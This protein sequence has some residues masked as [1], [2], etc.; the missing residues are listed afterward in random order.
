MD[1]IS[2]NRKMAMAAERSA[3][4][5]KKA[6]A[7][8]DQ[9]VVG[10]AISTANKALE[11]HGAVM[12]AY[13]KVMGATGALAE[14]AVVAVFSKLSFMQGLACLPASSQMD[15]VMGIDVH[16]VMIPPSPS[17]IP[18][19]HPYIAMVFNP[20]DFI[21]C[22]VMSAVAS[23]P[24]PPPDS[25]GKQLASTVGKMALGMVMAKLGLGASVKL[26]GFTPRTVTG[27]ANKVI[28]H[29]PMGASFAPL[30]ILKNSGHAQ[31][32][33]LFLLADG[34]PFTGMMHLNNDCWDIGI[35]QLMRKKA[36]AEPMHLFMPTGFVMAI[37]SH[38]VI[39]NPI[40]TPI[41]PIAALTKVFNFGLAKI[42]HKL[43]RKLPGG[44]VANALHKAVCHVTGHPV[45]I[46]SGMLFTDEEDFDLPGVIP[47][48]WER[49][50]YSDSIYKGPLG[51]GWYHNYDMGFSIDENN[52]GIFRM[53]DGRLIGFE[54]PQPGKFM[55]DRAE[56]YFLHRHA[57]EDYYYVEDKEG[58]LY[59]F[60]D[61]V[62]VNAINQTSEHLLQSV[63]NRNGYAIR[64]E[65][66]G[67]GHL[68]KMIDSAGRVL[69]V[70]NDALGRILSIHAP[71]PNE[72]GQTFP[73]ARYEY[74]E[75]G[76]M[77]R[78][79]DAL[80]QEMLYEYERTLLVKETWRNG[81]NWYFEYDG[82][83]PGAKCIHTW[84]DG[85]IY[86]HKLTYQ[87]GITL[88][89][90]SLGFFTTYYL[91]G[92]LISSKIDGNGAEWKYRYNKFNELEW[93]TDPLGNQQSY[94]HDEWGNIASM[95]DPGGG[96][97][98]TE[99]YNPK[100][101]F[102]PTEVL[103]AAG[104]K[105]KWYYDEYGNVVERIDPVNAKTKYIYSDG[106]LKSMVDANGIV[107]KLK[108]DQA[109]NLIEIETEEG[110]ITEYIYDL[111]G[112]CKT[113]IN[114]NGIKQKVLLDR[115]GRVE[116]IVDF[117]GNV[118][119]LTYD[120]MDNLV[121]YRDKLGHAECTYTGLWNLT[122]FSHPGGSVVFK[123]DTEEQ[124]KKIINEHGQSYTFEVDGEGNVVKEVNFNN[125]ERS[126]QYN[127]AGWLIKVLR[128]SD[129]F[130]KYT[131][132][133]CGR[134]TEVLYSDEKK[135]T[136]KYRPDGELMQA[137]NESA[138]VEF[139]RDLNGNINK[140]IVNGEWVASQ[141][142]ILGAL[143]KTESSLGANIFQKYN[144][145]G[146]ISQI[147]ANGWTATFD[148]DKLGLEIGR[149]LPGG[150]RNR[151]KRDGVGRPLIQ[152]VEHAVKETFQ[153]NR[154]RHYEW[155]VGNLI[156]VLKDERGTRSFKHDADINLQA[157]TRNGGELELRNPDSIGNI[158]KT[159][160]R[161][162]R[163][164]SK[165]GQLRKRDGWSYLYDAEGNLTQKMHQGGDV[166]NYAWNDAGMLIS[167][168]RPDKA[169]VTFEYDAFGRRISKRFKNTRTKFIWDANVP[170]H[171]WKEH[172]ETGEK[173][174]N[175]EVNS[176]G[177]IT[178]IFDN[179]S[180]APAA[181]IKGQERYSI[182]TDHL[183]TPSQIYTETGSLIW[184][185]E[186]D[187]Y[188]NLKMAI[189]DRGSCPFRFQGQYEDF[190]TGLYYNR[191]RYYAPDEGIYI[192]EDPIG[193]ES[194][195]LNFYRYVHDTANW[196]DVLGLKKTYSGNS[197]KSRKKN[198]VYKIFNK[199]TKEVFKFG[200]S[201]GKRTKKGDSVRA[202]SQ[203][204]KIAAQ[205]GIPVSDVGT[206]VVRSNIDRRSTALNIEQQK[207]N[208]H[209]TKH[210]QPPR[211]NK[212]PKPTN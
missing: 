52:T 92:G 11:V 166:W 55:Y 38:N 189:G 99:Y 84:G 181:K 109:Q 9:S 10:K 22:A 178:W 86:N 100:F 31:F 35:M 25:A 65:Y 70:K 164:Y 137:V 24:P 44:R 165:G 123:Y 172:A 54:L 50:W 40:P 180:S 47:F 82:K 129:K 149:K 58:L 53:N 91:K 112:N 185:G 88:V 198:H 177:V 133:P 48:S 2:E 3:A 127:D 68:V 163:A 20:K 34:E 186:L 169:L 94:T 60:T 49:T 80:D 78:H 104:G 141:Y 158:F 134:V 56:K 108:H 110:A 32:G 190:E 205:E 95:T 170:L 71:D 75:A 173:L 206:K 111:L 18:M 93:E 67:R 183:G 148:S 174:S 14:K 182:I 184:E 36:P 188:G 117:D 30:P 179:D 46:A 63:S 37:P 89:E 19:P 143:I 199:K 45:D 152:I 33:S 194:E 212:R 126:F 193:L 201:G 28:P 130:T 197:K 145:V 12:G 153:T 131:H 122:S 23:I 57:E 176:N 128:P 114:P 62:Y 124:L 51:H 8:A 187:S 161:K 98:H 61:R 115:K 150:V 157:V 21:A 208:S 97:I 147:D 135:E 90:N 209:N 72:V 87:E 139:E 69:E 119:E 207:V 107:T 85:D 210:K 59:R 74:D 202:N 105:W 144:R 151:W 106:I 200:I 203:K 6:A 27:T 196:V 26:G 4:E 167:V 77:V 120:G 116:R 211:Y 136:Y 101:P 76:N 132:D 113:T 195:E 160:D 7:P 140:E 41:N 43:I 125:V 191:F 79:I 171:E 138:I 192:S 1:K 39:V 13:G 15:P 102:L 154:S 73:I 64:F 118:I 42:L 29:F 5:A 155:G 121:R 175:T 156:K 168:T 17:P 103:D 83:E 146:D 142:D 159:L 204:A 81:M 162:D 96:F 66:N 16:M